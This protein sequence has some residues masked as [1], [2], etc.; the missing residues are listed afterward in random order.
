MRVEPSREEEASDGSV[1]LDFLLPLLT[2]DDRD[3]YPT[4]RVRTS[5]SS[6]LESN[7]FPP[8]SVAF[9]DDMFTEVSLELLERKVL[10]S[11]RRDVG[12]ERDERGD[13][14]GEAILRRALE[15]ERL[16]DYLGHVLRSEVRVGDLVVSGA[17][18]ESVSIPGMRRWDSLL[19]DLAQT[20]VVEI[21]V[22]L[23]F[24]ERLLTSSAPLDHCER[25]LD[26]Q[27][28]PQ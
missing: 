25:T 21:D 11:L 10:V 15:G 19:Q 24:R 7:H 22:L 6:P 26:S 13:G 20:R 9:P 16:V 3:V 27:Y 5:P 23:E 4:P 28:T 17:P 1:D 12:V 2:F 8:D 18:Y 14:G